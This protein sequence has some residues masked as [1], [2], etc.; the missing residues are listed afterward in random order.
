MKDRRSWADAS[1]M[2]G[3]PGVTRDGDAPAPPPLAR[4]KDFALGAA[5]VRPSRV[6]PTSSRRWRDAAG[7]DHVGALSR[8]TMC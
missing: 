8:V 6:R 3:R 2:N 4:R 7:C 1:P 5:V